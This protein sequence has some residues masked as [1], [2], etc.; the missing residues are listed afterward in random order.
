MEVT[1]APTIV[2]GVVGFL[3]SATIL[4]LSIRRDRRFQ[5]ER[6]FEDAAALRRALYSELD[7]VFRHYMN[8]IGYIYDRWDSPETCYIAAPI[9]QN[10]FS[11]FDNCAGRLGLLKEPALIQIV[12]Q[13]YVAGKGLIDSL[14]HFYTMVEK[15]NELSL[16]HHV[17][18]EIYDLEKLKVL[19]SNMGE[20]FQG[21]LSFHRN[22]KDLALKA[23]EALQR[24]VVIVPAVPTLPPQELAIRAAE[25]SA[26]LSREQAR[27][28]EQT[29]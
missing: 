21:N 8:G 28:P 24:G 7:A 20:Y 29:I 6:E 26:V 18:Q 22:F 1:L 3:S 11:V 19:E 23:I 15:R 5:K 12:I 10:Y 16:R 27:R 25:S 13:A 2:G 4:A 17:S 9:S 14:K